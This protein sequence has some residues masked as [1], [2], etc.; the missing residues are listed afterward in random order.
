[1][2]LHKEMFLRRKARRGAHTGRGVEER[3]REDWEMKILRAIA[4]T[5][6]P[7]SAVYF[8]AW[9]LRG[10]GSWHEFADYLVGCFVSFG[11]LCFA[12]WAWIQVSD[13]ERIGK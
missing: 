6:V 4:I 10:D 13:E 9:M 8:T 7:I 5:V 1:M 11:G 2:G 12:V 3:G